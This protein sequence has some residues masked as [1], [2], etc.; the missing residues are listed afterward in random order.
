MNRKT[1]L[2][3]RS[4][5]N[6]DPEIDPLNLERAIGYLYGRPLVK[7]DIVRIIRYKEACEILG[8]SYG[9]LQYF[10][11]RGYLKKVYGIGKQAIGITQESL[12]RFTTLRTQRPEV[13]ETVK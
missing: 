13:M 1:E 2:A 8:V 5:A 9:H 12:M 10:I 11:E 7:H 6:V 3:L 4:I